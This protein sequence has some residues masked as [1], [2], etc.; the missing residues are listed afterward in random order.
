MLSEVARV[1]SDLPE[2]RRQ[3]DAVVSYGMLDASDVEDSGGNTPFSPVAP[4]AELVVHRRV[5]AFSDHTG[6]DRVVPRVAVLIAS[7]IEDVFTAV[8]LVSES[9]SDSG[10]CSLDR[11]HQSRAVRDQSGLILFE[12]GPF[13]PKPDRFVP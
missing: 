6:S 10:R 13:W 1:T 3:L 12:V 2:F 8:G 5:A 11:S 9:W 4:L 7:G